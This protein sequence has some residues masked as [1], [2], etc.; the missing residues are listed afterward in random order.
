M[1]SV[2]NMA[3]EADQA[4]KDADAVLAAIYKGAAL[5][6]VKGRG[7]F[8]V[9]PALKEFAV[10]ALTNGCRLFVFDM[11]DCTGMDSTFMGVLA[12][13]AMKVKE[14][15]GGRIVLINMNT[16]SQNLLETLGVTRLVET[17]PVGDTSE[18]VKSLFAGLVGSEALS[19]AIDDRKLT[20]E[21]MLEAHEDLVKVSPDNLPKF[22]SVMAYLSADLKQVEGG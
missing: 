21:T 1:E 9:G 10:T 4:G 17:H 3:S 11:N 8:K 5:V 14:E 18:E 19:S 22:R 15:P 7:S 16:K 20:L 6:Q 13:V 2:N 12:G